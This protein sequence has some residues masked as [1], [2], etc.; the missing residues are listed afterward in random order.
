MVKEAASCGYYTSD[1]GTFQ[2]AP[3]DKKSE[4]KQGKVDI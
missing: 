3:K 1:F 4:G 2:K